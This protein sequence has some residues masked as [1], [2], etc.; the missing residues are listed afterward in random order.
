MVRTRVGYAGGHSAHPTYHDLGDHS[1]SIQIEFDPQVLTY[2]QLLQVAVREGAFDAP[3][4]S[5]Q[6]RSVVFFHNEEQRKAAQRAGIRSLEPAGEFTRAEDYHQ[7]YYLQQSA[8]AQEFYGMFA[9][10][11]AFTD[12]T[13]AARANGI[14]GGHVAKEQVQRWLPSLGVSAEGGQ[15]LLRVSP[16][17]G[18]GGCALPES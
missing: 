18:G 5:R 12:S 17:E 9:D 7:K 13:A 10:V 11:R 4:F 1:E 2:E 14:L 3:E 6:Y 16:R 8:L 15:T